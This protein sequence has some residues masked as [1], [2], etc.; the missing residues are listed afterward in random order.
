VIAPVRPETV[1]RANNR[2][3]FVGRAE[4]V[5][6][7]RSVR[8][9]RMVEEGLLLAL[10]PAVRY[11]EAVLGAESPLVGETLRSAGFRARYQA[12]VLAIHR[13]GH[14][15]DVKLGEVPLRVGDTLI[16]VADPAFRDRWRNLGDF[17]LV[18]EMDAVPPITS[19]KARL[20]GLVLLLLVGMAALGVLPIL[21][22]SLVAALAL[23]GLR[24]VTVDEARRAIDLDVIGV[25]ASAFGLAAAVESSGLAATLAGG[26]VRAFDGLGSRG[27]LLGVLLATI[28]LT[29]LITNNAAALLMFPLAMAAAAQASFDPRGLILAVAVG[30]SAS[31][32]TPIGYQTNTMVYGPGGYRFSDYFRLGWPLTL[33]VI[34]LTMWLVPIFWP[35]A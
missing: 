5:V 1:L 34:G 35:L 7:L 4:D 6:D 26:L 14:L 16:L 13:S 20:V 28:V 21:Q 25:I 33:V 24:I 30:A 27:V 23:I 18:A 32:L 12:A 3:R 10:D 15:I 22:G 11:F 29:E 19:R 2:L 8:G 31:F 9:L 17:I